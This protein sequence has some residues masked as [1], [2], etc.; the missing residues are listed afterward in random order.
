MKMLETRSALIA[1][2]L[3]AGSC[4]PSMS[5]ADPLNPL[6]FTSLGDTSVAPGVYTIDTDT[7]TITGP[8]TNIPGQILANRTVVFCFGN[9]L[10]SSDVTFNIV[11]NRP[12]AILSTGNFTMAADVNA[13]GANAS[14]T[15]PGA[16]R[17]TS[18]NGAQNGPKGNPGYGI[19]GGLAALNCGGSGGSFGAL[20][21]RGGG[22]ASSPLNSYGNLLRLVEGGSGGAGGSDASG[23]SGGAGGGGAAGLELGALGTLDVSGAVINLKG[24]NGA[25]GTNAAG[26]TAFGGHGGGGGAGGGILLHGATVVLGGPIDCSGGTGGSGGNGSGA[27]GGNGGGGGSGGRVSI[28]SVSPPVVTNI[29]VSGGTSGAG[30]TGTSSG[31]AGLNGGSG[32]IVNV[33]GVLTPTTLDFGTVDV[34]TSKVLAMEVANTGGTNSSINGRFPSGAGPF[35]RIG[36][37]VFSALRRDRTTSNDYSFTP[38][39]SGPFQQTLTFVSDGGNATVIIKGYGY[40]EADLNHDLFVDDADFALF[41]A[42]YDALLCP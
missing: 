17:G 13:S 1:F 39:A 30:G 31:T 23:T 32:N 4:V 20:G 10:V 14:G 2:A 40:C 35:A 34:G 29:T 11:G 24:G 6:D 5:L 36:T 41:A 22:I 27:A 9:I 42:D 33:A 28:Q 19:V 18:G 7:A 21:G 15:S 8:S 3:A 38:A 37:G 26:V 12:V 16:G 25:A